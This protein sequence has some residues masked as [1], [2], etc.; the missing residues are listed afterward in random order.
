MRGSG[1]GLPDRGEYEPSDSAYGRHPPRMRGIQYAVA[2]RFYHRRR[3]NT[4]SP[5]F[6]GD[7][8]RGTRLRDPA[9]C[10]ARVLACSF[11]PPIRGRRE[12]RVP[13]APMGPVQKK[14][15][16][17]T[18]GSTGITPAFPAQWFTAYSA[19]SPVTGLVC[20]RHWR[21]CFRQLDASVGASGPH[22]FAVRVGAVRQERRRVNRI[23]L[24]VRDDRERPSHGAGRGELVKVICPTRQVEYFYQKGWT[25][26]SDLPVGHR[27]MGG[28][29]GDYGDSALN[30]LR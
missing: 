16:G 9:A 6:A 12:S 28:A 10:F 20:H 14:H 2:F 26:N 13:I 29:A 4:G 7:D 25:E 30:G 22:G 24:H 18:T 5:A 27:W 15:G 11:R 8:N 3:W 23:L 1:D 21:N 17:R 19:L